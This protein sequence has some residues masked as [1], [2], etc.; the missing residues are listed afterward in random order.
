MSW[1]EDKNIDEVRC[2]DL[3][4]KA[5]LRGGVDHWGG[6]FTLSDAWNDEHRRIASDQER[7]CYEQ[8]IDCSLPAARSKAW[9]IEEWGRVQFFPKDAG[10]TT[11][12]IDEVESTNHLGVLV[13]I[14]PEDVSDDD[15]VF[16]ETPGQ[17][18][19]PLRRGYRVVYIPREVERRVG[20]ASRR[21]KRDRF[22]L[23]MR[24]FKAVTSG[25]WAYS[26]LSAHQA[27]QTYGSRPPRDV[28]H[29][30]MNIEVS[31]FWVVEGHPVR[32]KPTADLRNGEEDVPAGLLAVF[33]GVPAPAPKK[34]KTFEEEEEKQD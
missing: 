20:D 7:V 11:P 31:G 26:R 2:L 9:R 13:V 1:L 10:F 5:T 24:V 23:I 27:R 15:D 8:F 25:C 29:P 12:L 19:K 4:P 21:V 22:L 16:L 14:P 28:S 32:W 33:K 6:H 3:D 17:V 30:F 18:W 34:R